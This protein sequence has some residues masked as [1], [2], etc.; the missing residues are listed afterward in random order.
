M[1]SLRVKQLCQGLR[2]WNSVLLTLSPN[3][4]GGPLQQGS[5]VGSQGDDLGGVAGGGFVCAAL[6]RGHKRFPGGSASPRYEAQHWGKNKLRTGNLGSYSLGDLSSK[7]TVLSCVEVA[8][9]QMQ[10]C[11]G[12]C[13]PQPCPCLQGEG[14]WLPS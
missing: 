6:A 10:L 13:C 5:F 14:Q 11:W 2:S 7:R 9:Q 3:G 8:S 12:Y 1:A 4:V